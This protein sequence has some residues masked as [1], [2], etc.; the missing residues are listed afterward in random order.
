M[1]ALIPSLEPQPPRNFDVVDVL[2][3]WQRTASRQPWHIQPAAR[4]PSLREAAAL[5]DV[6]VDLAVHPHDLREAAARTA[7][8]PLA[9]R[10]EPDEA[11]AAVGRAHERSGRRV[12]LTVLMTLAPGRLA[13]L[14]IHLWL[15][16]R[17]VSAERSHAL[18][19]PTDDHNGERSRA[20]PHAEARDLVALAPSTTTPPSHARILRAGTP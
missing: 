10:A 8:V 17:I 14:M 1:T 7:H 4:A 11:A 3:A 13:M 6:R 5:H 16:E 15:R 2:D 20:H 18:L 19:K 9:T 12:A